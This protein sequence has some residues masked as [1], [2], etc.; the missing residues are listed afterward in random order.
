MTILINERF[1]ADD[2]QRET[3]REFGISC[4]HMCTVVVSKLATIPPDSLSLGIGG[5]LLEVNDLLPVIGLGVRGP[6]VCVVDLTNA[7]LR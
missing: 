5:P 2:L 3:K 6:R 4:R 1:R 7:L